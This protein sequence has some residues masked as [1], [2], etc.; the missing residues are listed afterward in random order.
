MKF[1]AD[2]LWRSSRDY[3]FIT[4]GVGIYAFGFCAFI[5]PQGVVIGGLAGIGTLVYLT[6]G[7]PVAI[8][9][10]VLNL[11]LLAW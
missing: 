1:S 5:L 8:T 10:Y 6:M 9:Q 7:I 4:L 2:K 3:L 11:L